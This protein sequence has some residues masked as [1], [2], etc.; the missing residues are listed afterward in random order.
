MW[1]NGTGSCF[2]FQCKASV[3]VH[4]HARAHTHT[5]THAHTHTHT[6]TIFMNKANVA[7]FP[8]RVLAC[9]RS[10]FCY[11]LICTICMSPL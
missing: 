5:H 1:V 11:F 8:T 2:H 4:T 3:N 6:H 7:L 9:F 10:I